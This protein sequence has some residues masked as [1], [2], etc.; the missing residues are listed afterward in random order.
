[1]T[2]HQVLITDNSKYVH[3][4]LLIILELI[5]FRVLFLKAS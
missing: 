5:I 1:M 4:L 3:K 2:M